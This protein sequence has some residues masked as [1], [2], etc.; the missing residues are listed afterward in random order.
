[1]PSAGMRD[2]EVLLLKY[3]FLRVEFLPALPCWPTGV[4]VWVFVEKKRKWGGMRK[5][6]EPFH[7]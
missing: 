6:L 5:S 7:A 1:M 3:H 2:R 4:G